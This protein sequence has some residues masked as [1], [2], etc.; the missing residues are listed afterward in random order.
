MLSRAGKREDLPTH[1]RTSS[2][3]RI[4]RGRAR[5]QYAVATVRLA[6]GRLRLQ[7]LVDRNSS[8]AVHRRRTNQ[9]KR[10]QLAAPP[11]AID[12]PVR[13]ASPWR[14]EIG[15]ERC[16]RSRGFLFIFGHCECGQFWFW[17]QHCRSKSNL[18]HTH[19]THTHHMPFTFTVSVAR[20]RRLLACSFVTAATTVL[21]QC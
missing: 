12:P 7:L 5:V 1:P 19:T 21:L 11:I 6:R 8:V 18:P 10:V 9:P 3:R 17:A 13:L 2:Y 15:R 20:R 16:V 4:G 14:M